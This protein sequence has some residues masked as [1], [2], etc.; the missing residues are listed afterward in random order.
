MVAKCLF[1]MPNRDQVQYVATDM[2]VPYRDAVSAALPEAIIVIDKFHVARVADNA[3]G[4]ARKGPRGADT[5]AETQAGARPL[6]VLEARMHLN[7]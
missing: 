2:W 3:M 4:K 1:K 6:R 5:K 7:R